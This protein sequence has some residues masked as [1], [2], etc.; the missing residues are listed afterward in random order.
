MSAANLINKLMEIERAVSRARAAEMHTMVLEAQGCVLEIQRQMIEMLRE[1]ARLREK[2]EKYEPTSGAR[3]RQALLPSNAEVA[4]EL[5]RRA[6]VGSE[7]PAAA[8]LQHLAAS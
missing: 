5:A 4:W 8:P 6:R 7:E 3:K 2:M 1:N